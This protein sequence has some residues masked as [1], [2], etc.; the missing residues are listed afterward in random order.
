ML[1]RPNNNTT[2][3]RQYWLS[4]QIYIIAICSPMHIH[5]HLGKRKTL[6]CYGIRYPACLT[7][8]FTSWSIAHFVLSGDLI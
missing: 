8:L 3:N 7:N 5:E 6:T 4:N 1:R 2:L